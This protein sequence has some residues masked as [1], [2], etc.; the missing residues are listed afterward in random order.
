M[1]SGSWVVV[2]SSFITAIRW[3]EEGT[4]VVKYGGR[5]IFRPWGTLCVAFHTTDVWEFKGVSRYDYE[6]I[7]KSESVGRAFSYLVKQ[8]RLGKKIGNYKE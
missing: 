1:K 8:G 4:L 6:T 7:L 2:D 5:N 3:E